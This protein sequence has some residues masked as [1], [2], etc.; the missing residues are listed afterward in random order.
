MTSLV[1]KNMSENKKFTKK[2]NWQDP[3]NFAQK[4]ADNYGDESWAF[5]YSGLSVD[6]KKSVSYIAICP[7]Q[8]IVA[9]SFE[10]LEKIAKNQELWFGYLSYELVHELE[11]FPE[12]KNSHINLPKIWFINFGLVFKFDHEEKSLTAFFDD[13]VKLEEALKYQVLEANQDEVRIKNLESNFSNESYLA[14]ISDIKKMIAEGD[15]YQTN[16]TRKFFGKLD[17]K[18][19]SPSAYFSLFARLCK[20]SPANY[21]S[22]LSFKKNY[23]IS[24]SPELFLDLD[25]NGIVKSR[26]IKGTSARSQDDLQDEKNKSDL[27]NSPKE[28]AEN[29][30]IVDLV[31][32]D[33]SRVCKAGSVEVKNLFE[34]ISYKTIHHM[35]S[36]IV[37]QVDEKF[38]ALDV[39][40]ACFPAGSMTGAPKVK[41]M[42]VVAK[43]E[44]LNRGIYSGAIGLIGGEEVKLSVVIR[45]LICFS[46]D[47]EFQVGGAITFDS[48]EQKE[49]EEIF[50]KAKGIL[51]LLGVTQ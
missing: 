27:Q 32:N 20:I 35:V 50:N 41:A 16:L 10:S 49:L 37:G 47:F 25:E 40:K 34:V 51:K 46:D 30:M 48:D 45:T 3:L 22:F 24:A 15:F 1:I 33:L 23:I 42:Q 17:I 26:P 36:E 18:D 39:I 12:T 28:R 6:V 7:R 4:I 31:R 5:L 2:L 21:S 29:L 9:D 13:E 11:K 43:K 19:K 8:E 14:E 44:K 38:S